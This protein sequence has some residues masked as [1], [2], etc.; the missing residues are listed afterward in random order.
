MIETFK[1][2]NDIG[3][4]IEYTVIGKYKDNGNM[5][6]IYTDFVSDDNKV[7]IRLFADIQRDGKLE[8]LEKDKEK[9]IILNFNKELVNYKIK[10]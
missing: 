10:V 9:E 5:Y 3:V 7:G 2:K 8:R 6:Y 1:R 4:D